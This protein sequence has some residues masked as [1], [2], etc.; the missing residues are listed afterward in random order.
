MLAI[1]PTARTR[2]VTIEQ[3]TAAC[4]RRRSLPTSSSAASSATAGVDSGARDSEAAAPSV[5]QMFD[6]TG[7]VA[8][9]TGGGTWLGLA[10]ATALCE[11]GATVVLASRRVELCEAEASALRSRHGFKCFATRCD[12][13]DEK[14]VDALIQQTVG[15]HGRLDVMICNAGG[16]QTTTYIPNASIDEFQASWESNVKSTYMCAQAAARQMQ[17]QQQLPGVDDGSCRG[18]IITVGSIHGVL[19]GDK[20]LYD[21]LKGFNRSGPPYQAAKGA[22]VNLTRA[23]ACELGDWGISVNCERV[24]LPPSLSLSLARSLAR[25]RIHFTH[26]HTWPCG[27]YH[28]RLSFSDALWCVLRVGVHTPCVLSVQASLQAKFR[29]RTALTLKWWNAA[30][31]ITRCRPLGDREI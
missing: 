10:M 21:G 18:K 16:S 4:C 11:L 2:L 28:N 13:T 30:G 31:S 23:L 19:S 15:E 25:A 14:S 5:L 12:V 3:H 29:R 6:L 1:S 7:R 27:I 17:H 26:A 24:S 8:I 9:V 20:R 22:V